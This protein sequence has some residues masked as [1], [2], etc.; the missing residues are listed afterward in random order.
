MFILARLRV[1]DGVLYA[2]SSWS[3][4]YAIDARHGTVRWRYDPAVP[5]EHAKFVC[6]DVVNR[7]V[8]LFGDKVYVG[9]IDG[10]LIALDR[11]TGAPMWSRYK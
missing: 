6:C 10:R 7:G 2:T 4:V 11:K 9:T 3:V 8:A 1:S 5:K